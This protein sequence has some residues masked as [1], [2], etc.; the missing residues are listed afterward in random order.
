V[1]GG[2]SGF[3][4]GALGTGGPPLVA[5]YQLQGIDKSAFRVNLITIFLII[6]LVRLPCYAMAG[7][8][9]AT[10]LRATLLLLPASLLGA[11]IGARLHLHLN[12][13]TFR[14]AVGLAVSL[15]GIL[16]LAIRL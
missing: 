14:R 9:D 3:L 15:L 1:V 6:S 4:A 13:N 2:I 10:R 11:W 8:L 7:L 12:E 5:Y 16:T